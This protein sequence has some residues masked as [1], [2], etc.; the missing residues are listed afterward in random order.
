M[1][2]RVVAGDMP[3]LAF[4][5][6]AAAGVPAGGIGNFTWDW[7]YEYY[8]DRVAL[9]PQLLPVMRTAYA[10][11]TLAWR[12]PMAGGFDP[13]RRIIDVPLVARHA[14]RQP[15]D[16][17]EAL[18]LPLD[19]PLV[20]ISFGRYGLRTVDWDAVTREGDFGVLVT[21]DPDDRGPTVRTAGGC[22]RVYT[23]DVPSMAERGFHYEDLVAAVDVVL[24][25]PGY[26][27]IAECAANNTALVY[28]SRG[29][30]AE[31]AVL[32]EAMPRLLRCAYIDQG[33]LFAG[34]W[35]PVMR[36]VLGQAAVAPPLP[37]ARG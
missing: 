5:A 35:A 15:T 30:F 11:A 34:R 22:D 29:D 7:I 8:R 16:T 17:R 31:Y 28:T 10:T 3:P 21:H 13:F 25:K 6:A 24:T 1:T 14:H 26:G 2:P 4:A 37:T 18:G 19:Q 32:V 20:L 27:I 36:Q 12:L 23:V 9:P 33:D